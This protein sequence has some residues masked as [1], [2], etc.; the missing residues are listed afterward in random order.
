M[1]DVLHSDNP[2]RPGNLSA[3]EYRRRLEE[4]AVTAPPCHDWTGVDLVLDDE[5]GAR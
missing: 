1:A 2:D 3:E 4:R 5:D